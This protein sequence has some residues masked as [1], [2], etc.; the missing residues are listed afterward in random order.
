[1]SNPLLIYLCGNEALFSPLL[2]DIF[3]LLYLHCKI[4]CGL[5]FFKLD[6][7]KTAVDLEFVSLTKL[8]GGE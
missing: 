7:I 6:V 5:W 1:M 2:I 3:L 8:N 4:L